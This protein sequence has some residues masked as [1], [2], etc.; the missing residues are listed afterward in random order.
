MAEGHFQVKDNNLKIMSCR[1]CIFWL[2]DRLFGVDILHVKEI[3]QEMIF[4][5]IFHAADEIR[6]M[7]NIRGY[8]NLVVDLSQ[9][10]G[11]GRTTIDKHSAVVI[12]KQN[13]A[14]SLGVLVKKVE[15]VVDI[16]GDSIE[17]AASSNGLQ[18]VT[19][20]AKWDNV[21]FDIIDPGC[22]MKVSVQEL[23]S[24]FNV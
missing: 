8:I 14:E 5:K 6:G 11:L 15:G 4:T 10:I 18:L 20:V 13:I 12:F 2:S 16:D 19:G 1:Y 3:N 24:S 21:L 23:A 17:P 22:F 9:L 7:V